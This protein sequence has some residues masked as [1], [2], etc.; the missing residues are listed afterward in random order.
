MRDF[1]L[2]FGL[3]RRKETSYNIFSKVKGTKIAKLFILVLILLLLCAFEKHSANIKIFYDS[4]HN[5]SI[6]SNDEFFEACIKMLGAEKQSFF[7]IT[8]Q[9][10][11]I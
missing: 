7:I 11:L 9:I 10:Y 6:E 1:H 3:F 8:Y 4:N 5:N 2:K